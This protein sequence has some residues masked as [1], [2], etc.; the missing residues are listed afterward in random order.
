MRPR[1]LKETLEHDFHG[2]PD[3]T[4]SERDSGQIDPLGHQAG[5]PEEPEPDILDWLV[6]R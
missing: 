2:D 3:P 4:P 5:A 6:G 1:A